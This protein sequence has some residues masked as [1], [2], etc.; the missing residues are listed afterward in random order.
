MAVSI[1]PRG[2]AGR[3][4]PAVAAGQARGLPAVVAR[5]EDH[6]RRAYSWCSVRRSTRISRG[7]PKAMARVRLR[8]HVRRHEVEEGQSPTAYESFETLQ[9][10]RATCPA[11]R[12]DVRGCSTRVSPRRRCGI[13]RA[14][15]HAHHGDHAVGDHLPAFGRYRTARFEGPVDVDLAHARTHGEGRP[16]CRATRR[17]A[18]CCAWSEKGPS[19]IVSFPCSVPRGSVEA[20]SREGRARAVRATDPRRESRHHHR[21]RGDLH[22][23]ALAR[24]RDRP[25]PCRRSGRRC[26]RPRGQAAA[27]GAVG[28]DLRA[29]GDRAA[30]DEL[31]LA[32]LRDRHG[33]ADGALVSIATPNTASVAEHGATVSFAVCLTSWPRAT[34]AETLY[35]L[36]WLKSGT[37]EVCMVLALSRGP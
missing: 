18:A 3:V 34:A 17:G 30:R 8:L 5:P 9:W 20:L 10:M 33:A 32:A 1:T 2:V 15:L 12:G 31:R 7:V 24:V 36:I 23:G 35:A 26:C 13:S 28:G 27:A 4:V 25:S 22:D 6:G 16:R 29:A 14:G 19:A 37:G 11:A 21:A